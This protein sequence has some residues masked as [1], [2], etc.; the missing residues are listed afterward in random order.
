MTDAVAAVTA[1]A[2][3]ME[4]S[5]TDALS[6]DNPQSDGLEIWG[7]PGAVLNVAVISED[8]RRPMPRRA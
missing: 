6:L 4:P 2:A 7:A 1:F 3:R 5:A 8:W